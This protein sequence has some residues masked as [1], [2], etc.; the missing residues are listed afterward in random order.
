M[1]IKL[2]NM[3]NPPEKIKLMYEA[4]SGF[5]RE[6]R[7][8]SSIKVSDI[9]ARAGIGKGTAY[10]YF[11]SKEELITNALMYEYSQKMQQLAA[12]AFAPDDFRERCYKIMDW[13]KDNKEYNHMFSRMISA[14]TVGSQ[15][16]VKK[17]GEDC[18]PPVFIQ[19]AHDYIYSLIDQFMEEGYV[20]GAF[21]ET[22]VGKRSLAL[23]TAMVEYSFVIMGPREERYYSVGEDGMRAFIYESLI[24]ALS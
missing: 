16:A 23:L 11:S 20:R 1:E 5:I 7:D 14:A 24:K 12:A 15:T 19:Q 4:V 13:I 8:I 17:S 3:L 21:T 22:N 2:D 10:E 18:T 6:Q 9:T